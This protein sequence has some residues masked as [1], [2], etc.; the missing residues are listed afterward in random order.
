MAAEV[1]AG[2]ARVAAAAAAAADEAEMETS[3]VAW[4]IS[5]IRLANKA[6]VN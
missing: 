4:S 3:G 6:K 5:L 1:A 2:V